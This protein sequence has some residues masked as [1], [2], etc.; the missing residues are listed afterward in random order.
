MAE[1]P[2]PS[3]LR[4][5]LQMQRDVARA[6]DQPARTEAP[7]DES[8]K[9]RRRKIVEESLKQFALVATVE[10]KQRQRELEDLK[11]DRAL[12]E[13]HWSEDYMRFRKGGFID[14]IYVAPRPCLTIN[15]LDQ[16]VQQVINEARQ[17]RLAIIIKPKANGA[18]REGAEVRQGLIRSIEV[19]SRAHVARLWALE[20][21]VKCGRGAYRVV[22]E[23]ANDGDADL[24]III[25]A[26]PNQACVYFDPNAQEFDWSDGEWCIITN[27]LSFAE[28]ERRFGKQARERAVSAD[29][30]TIT[31]AAGKWV[32]E[33]TIRVAERFYVEFDP[34]HVLEL[35]DGRTRQVTPRHVKWCI[36]D[37]VEVLEEEDWPG[38]YIPV[39]PVIGKHYNV[40]GE[41]CWK[42]IVSN[43]K[44]AQRSFN[45]GRSAQ[46]EAVAL[47]PKAPWVVVEGQTKGYKQIW[48]NANNWAGNYLPYNPVSHDGQLV[49]P[50]QRN[51]VEPPVQAI[52]LMVREAD[53]D[54]KSTTGRYS[55]S[56]GEV[57]KERS[58]KAIRELKQQG[59]NTTSNY[60]ENLATISMHLEGK[61]LLD[62]LKHVYDRPGRIARILGDT[63][64]DER[65]VMLG[66]PYVEGE[67]GMPRPVEPPGMLQRAG[68]AVLG[69]VQGMIG[70]QPPPKPKNYDLT[71]GD[72]SVV[73]S[74]GRS[75]Q[76]QREEDAAV[77]EAIFEA[78]PQLVPVLGHLWLESM[79]S[80]VAKKSAD[81]LR[82]MSP[83]GQEDE[84]SQ[85]PPQVQMMIQQMQ[86][87]MQ[88]MQQ[89]LETERPKLEA[90][91]QMKQMEL[92][93]REKIAAMQI[94]ADLEKAKA[95]VAS[96]ESLAV[97]EA[98]QEKMAQEAEFAHERSMKS[99]E[100][101]IERKGD[102]RKTALS[103]VT[104]PKATGTA[105]KPQTPT[106]KAPKEFSK[107]EG[108]L[109]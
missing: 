81:I 26:I 16:P 37:A 55:P 94:G 109:F 91:V 33:D 69:A 58:G 80:P 20:R 88:E 53:Q 19:D 82:K 48:D 15:K 41:K 103:M 98:A 79:D 84:N 24:D 2:Y 45:F 99:L 7:P 43:S 86:Q 92:A 46:V 62:L 68:G 59:E 9:A 1:A 52:T 12:P 42:G 10:S 31:D 44:D 49:P 67:D 75:Y 13:D 101:D 27:D 64:E 72:Y 66:Q 71:Q 85:I 83:A 74:V 40:D 54:I 90:A 65:H 25:K 8:E 63:P 17:A 89:A 108:P 38:R 78:A 51:V 93:S 95:G 39:I 96:K 102:V 36:H 70:G 87:Q 14:G 73:V 100:G 50:P 3:P 4:G 32:T 29:L 57:S 61:M 11:F 107:T 60:L 76:T 6:Y 5:N 35:G 23:Y 22:T 34:P 30:T 97:L 21:A 28:Y 106:V 105:G 47:A 18:N 77:M 56:L 104:G